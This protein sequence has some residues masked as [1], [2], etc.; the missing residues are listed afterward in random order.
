[1][2][3]AHQDNLNKL[4]N[5]IEKCA[6]EIQSYAYELYLDN[7]ASENGMTRQELDDEL[8][9][10][11]SYYDEFDIMPFGDFVDEMCTQND[12]MYFLLPDDMYEIYTSIAFHM[13][14][15]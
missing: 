1:M 15:F 9:L 3:T 11:E 13:N 4:H 2:I 8:A 10:N 14:T 6:E 5:A 12:Y 7:K